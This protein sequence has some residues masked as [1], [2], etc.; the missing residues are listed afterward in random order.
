SRINPTL[1]IQFN[2]KGIAAAF[3]KNFKDF[4]FRMISPDRLAQKVDVLGDFRTD[5]G[6][7]SASLGPVDPPIRA[8]GETIGYRM[9]VF[10]TKTPE[11][12]FRIAIGQSIIIR[13]G[14]SQEIGRIENP[15]LTPAHDDAGGYVQSGDGIG[16][17]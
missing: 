1:G 13:I 5:M 2:I 12:Y 15:D 9:G 4:G 17:L 11:M 14:V 6:S 8:P 3:R 7:G 10:Q 16:S